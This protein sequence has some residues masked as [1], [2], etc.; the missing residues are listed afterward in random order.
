MATKPAHDHLDVRDV[1][2]A[3]TVLPVLLPVTLGC[4]AAWA[5]GHLVAHLTVKAVARSMDMTSRAGHR[6]YYRIA[7]DFRADHHWR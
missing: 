4:L 3:T 1:V 7:P 6:R 5:A 2:R